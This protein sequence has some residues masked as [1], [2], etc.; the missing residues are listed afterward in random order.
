EETTSAY[1]QLNIKGE[2]AEMPLAVST[3]L[4]YEST[5]VESNSYQQDPN[6]IV[7]N[8]PTEWGI[9]RDMEG[10]YTAEFGDYDVWLPSLDATLEVTD[11]VVARF[12]F[13]QSLTRPRLGALIGTTSITDRPKPGERTGSIG[14]PDLLPYTSNNLD[15]SA[16]WYYDN[17][18]YVSVGLFHKQVSNFIVDEFVGMEVFGLRDPLQGERAK[19][20]RAELEADGLSV[21]DVNVFNRMN[22][23]A[24]SAGA[25]TQNG[26]DPLAVFE[27]ATPR[28]FEN[29][30]LQGVE[31]AIQH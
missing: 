26:D 11:S 25:I 2:L 13:S 31:A 6:A 1:F 24:G 16:E 19:Q 9:T 5:D 29:A 20:A 21:S 12:G 8:N 27:I 7:W 18:S 17:A 23:I 3:G 22:E 28:N 4:R 30:K 15:V 10:R 14:V